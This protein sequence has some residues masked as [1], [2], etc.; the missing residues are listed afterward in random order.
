MSISAE[1]IEIHVKGG[2]SDRKGIKKYSDIVQVNDLNMRTRN[3]IFNALLK[4]FTG[5]DNKE[6]SNDIVTYVYTEIFSFSVYDIPFQ[7]FGIGIDFSKTCQILNN[8]IN[9]REYN[10]VFD[11]IEGIIQGI[12]SLEEYYSYK[13]NQ[14][15]EDINDIFVNENVNYRIVN[16]IITDLVSEEEITSIDETLKNPYN[17]V[18]KHYTNALNKLYKDKDYAN[19]IKESISSVEAMCQVINGGKEELNKAL[20][21]L[22]IVIHPALEQAYIKL[23]AYTCDENGARHANGIGEKD[24]SFLEA[25]YMLISCSA[26]VNYLRENFENK[27]E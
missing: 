10:E 15:I 12:N 14:L 26:F 9:K 22:K 8:Q 25:K 2:F 11:L 23:Y 7:E 6:F 17:T 3:K 13:K 21:N 1:K 18:K 19:S 16:E 24:A 4:L 27:E 20:K 5:D